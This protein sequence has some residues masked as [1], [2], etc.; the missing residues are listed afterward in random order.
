LV[1]DGGKLDD[2]IADT[3]VGETLPL[4]FRLLSGQ[5]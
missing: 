3:I 2:S 1:V 5:R 4:G